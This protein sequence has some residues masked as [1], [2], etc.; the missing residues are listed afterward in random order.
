MQ[1][2]LVHCSNCLAT[3]ALK[4]GQK[5]ISFVKSCIAFSEATVP[6]ISSHI[7]QLNLYTETAEVLFLSFIYYSCHY[8]YIYYCTNSCSTIQVALLAG[9]VSH[10]DGLIDSVIGCLQNAELINGQFITFCCEVIWLCSCKE[11][12]IQFFMV[13]ISN[14]TIVPYWSLPSFSYCYQT[15]HFHFRMRM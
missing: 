9:L 6:S 13:D 8:I 5:H 2:T 15:F 4:N 3:K 7:R 1:E 14:V 11:D 10:L 12:Y